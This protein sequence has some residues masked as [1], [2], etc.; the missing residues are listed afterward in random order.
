MN[1]SDAIVNDLMDQWNAATTHAFTEDLCSDVLNDV[2]WKK[3]LIQDYAFV[4]ALTELVK[5]MIDKCPGQHQ[6][7]I[8][9]GFLDV[10]TGAEDQFFI[11]AFKKANVPKVQWSSEQES[12]VTVKFKEL[13]DR[14]NEGSYADVLSV[15]LP[16]EWIYLTWATNHKNC[17]PRDS[18]NEWILLHNNEEFTEFVMFLKSEF[19]DASQGYSEEDRDRM[20]GYFYTACELEVLFF[21]HCYIKT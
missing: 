9:E 7:N 15:L 10:L 11:D 17:K 21:D 6:R 13:F 2:S 14:V 20:T 4:G 5:M 3:Y 16:V 19:D 18:Y 8:F 1:L 12:D